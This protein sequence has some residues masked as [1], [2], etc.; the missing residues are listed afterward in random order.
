MS[1]PLQVVAGFGKNPGENEKQQCGEYEKYVSHR[2][3]GT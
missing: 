2:R 1:I 3:L